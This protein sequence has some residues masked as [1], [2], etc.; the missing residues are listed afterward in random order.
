MISRLDF[1]EK[2]EELK[3][4]RRRVRGREWDRGAR[5]LF[6]ARVRT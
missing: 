4:E 5:E 1:G 3:R 6:P 2:R